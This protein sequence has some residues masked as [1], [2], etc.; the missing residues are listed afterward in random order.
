MKLL[1]T[2]R[3]ADVE[4][5]AAEVRLSPDAKE[6]LLGRIGASVDAGEQ[7]VTAAG[8]TVNRRGLRVAVAIAAAALLASVGWDTGPLSQLRDRWQPGSDSVAPHFM[9]LS[10]R[11]QQRSSAS[12]R[13]R[14]E[15]RTTT[16]PRF[17]LPRIASADA[18]VNPSPKA[19]PQSPGSKPTRPSQAEAA[20]LP[21]TLNAEILLLR[22]ARQASSQG[23]PR[24]ALR[25]IDAHA[26]EFPSG[27]LSEDRQRLR[28]AVLCSSGRRD[29][30]RQLLSHWG[31][32][33]DRRQL[34]ALCS[35][36]TEAALERRPTEE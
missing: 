1:P 29:E 30:G 9:A 10:G 31:S 3:R 7:P 22:R 5:Y 28:V 27:Q 33:G 23:H 11:Q 20:P 2:N 14:P 26:L 24:E 32:S 25:W 17:V 19:P 36:P 16:R 35:E 12:V 34:L 18:E 21:S 13:L 6:R 15:R 8:S 4:A